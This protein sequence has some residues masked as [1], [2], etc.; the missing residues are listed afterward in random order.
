MLAK[1]MMSKTWKI[2]TNPV[3]A[4]EQFRFPMES[5]SQ[6]LSRGSAERGRFLATGL[7]RACIESIVELLSSEGAVGGSEM[8]CEIV[9]G[10]RRVSYQIINLALL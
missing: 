8:L 6:V 3:L 5:C 7:L 9:S 1:I 4:D 10:D 2:S